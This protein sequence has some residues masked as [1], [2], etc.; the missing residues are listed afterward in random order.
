LTLLKFCSLKIIPSELFF[1]EFSN[2]KRVFK[3]NDEAGNYLKTAC[4]MYEWHNYDGAVAN[5]IAKGM[6][7]FSIENLDVE[8]A[9]NKL[10]KEYYPAGRWWINGERIGTDCPQFHTSSKPVAYKIV[11]AA[12]SMVKFSYCEILE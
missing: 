7:I 10:S 3:L 5:C 2:C 11:S 6:S 8:I 9:L 12:C 1:S 4:Q